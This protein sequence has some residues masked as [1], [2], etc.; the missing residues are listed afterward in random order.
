MSYGLVI[1]NADGS[2]AI[3]E[4]SRP[5]RLV[6]HE[7]FAWDFSGVRH[8]PAFD[9]AKG[10]ISVSFGFHKARGFPDFDNA[11]NAAPLD[12]QQPGTVQIVL[13]TSSMPTL[14]WDNIAKTLSISPA[15]F[16]DTLVSGQSPFAIFMVMFR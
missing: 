16:N 15:G 9:D 13:D 11:D 14:N 10:F 3:D 1:R 6:F 2:V 4:L 5:P 12:F 7:Q 8:V